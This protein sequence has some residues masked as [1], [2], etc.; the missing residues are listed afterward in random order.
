MHLSTVHGK[1]G[2]QLR[3]GKKKKGKRRNSERG[4]ANAQSKHSHNIKFDFF[5][6]IFIRTHDNFYFSRKLKKY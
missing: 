4:R 2:Q 3:L 6:R 5:L 1:F